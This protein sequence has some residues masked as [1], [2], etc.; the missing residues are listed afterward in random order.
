MIFMSNFNEITLQVNENQA[1]RT[2]VY[3][4]VLYTIL[5]PHG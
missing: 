3:L 4:Q 2:A 1:L 5:T